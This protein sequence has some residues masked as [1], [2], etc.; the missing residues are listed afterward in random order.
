V[1]FP[2]A[3]R[4]A[5]WFYDRVGGANMGAV[6]KVVWHTTETTGWPGYDGGSKAPHYTV[7]PDYWTKT[8]VWRQHFPDSVNS[9]AM[10]NEPGGVQTN[11]DG[12]LQVEIVGTCDETRKW[13]KQA[14]R[15]WDLEDW[16]VEGLAEFV[17]WAHR[18]HGVPLAAPSLWLAYGK[19]DRAPGRVPASY[20]DSPARMTGRTWDRF[21]GHCGHQHAPENS[22]GDP[23][24][25]PMGQVLARA[26]VLLEPPPADL[27][28]ELMAD[29]KD[30]AAL[31]ADLA[32][33]VL[34]TPQPLGPSARRELNVER[35]SLFDLAAIA[36]SVAVDTRQAADRVEA[37][38]ADGVTVE[39]PEQPPATP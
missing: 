31:I 18:E 33:E 13:P 30:R 35:A 36:A 1:G 10:R 32:A 27:L 22:H 12:A 5:Q 6:E 11:L 26:A 7:L 4:T 14:L 28:E 15:S 20:G 21:R 24:R 3:S 2:P 39:Q 29:P 17:A 34:H 25:L 9:R 37:D 38:L 16:Q 23:G 8:M 19:D